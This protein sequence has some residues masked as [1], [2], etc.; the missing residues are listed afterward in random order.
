MELSALMEAVR[1]GD[2]SAARQ[3]HAELEPE[4]LGY[5]RRRVSTGLRSRLDPEDVFQETFSEILLALRN[6][7]RPIRHPDRFAKTV[8]RHILYRAAQR[9]SLAFQS[10]DPAASPG[11]TSKGGVQ[12]VATTTDPP[13]R[14]MR[15]ERTVL[16]QEAL[17]SL[18]PQQA[19]IVRLRLETEPRPKFTEIGDT[20][21][22]SAQAAERAYLR[23]VAK[24]RQY[25]RHHRSSPTEWKR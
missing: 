12:P 13:G 6:T 24:I 25:L 11:E 8:A 4:L 22:M 5:I 16:F 17:S 9:K 1:A 14:M 21:G 19:R 20:V 3:L 18:T 7:D 23:A 10:L 2:E 15:K